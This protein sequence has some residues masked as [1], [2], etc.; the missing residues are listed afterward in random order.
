MKT[1]EIQTPG[2]PEIQGSPE[3]KVYTF[4]YRYG[5]AGILARNFRHRGDLYSAINRAKSHCAVMNYRFIFCFP[6]IVDLDIIEDS[7]RNNPE[8]QENL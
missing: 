7:R 2:V 8:F 4:N 6:F 5:N 3:E 1:E